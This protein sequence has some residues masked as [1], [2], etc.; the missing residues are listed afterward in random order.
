MKQTR[1][2]IIIPKKNRGAMQ[3]STSSSHMSTI[4]IIVEQDPS[5]KKNQNLAWSLIPWKKKSNS[6]FIKPYEHMKIAM[7]NGTIPQK[8]Q[9]LSNLS[10][11]EDDKDAT[12]WTTFIIL[13]MLLHI[14]FGIVK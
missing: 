6:I 3:P 1:G 9:V 10:N 11:E 4:P 12:T 7:K 14:P 13:H 8:W 5:R 2:K